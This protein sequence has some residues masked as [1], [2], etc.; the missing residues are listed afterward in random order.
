MLIVGVDLRKNWLLSATL[1]W[2]LKR[3]KV[4]GLV[5]KLKER[6]DAKSSALFWKVRRW[7]RVHP[8]KLFCCLSGPAFMPSLADGSRNSRRS[9]TYW[10]SALH[11][12]VSGRCHVSPIFLS[13]PRWC[14]SFGFLRLTVHDKHLPVGACCTRKVFFLLSIHLE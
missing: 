3:Q 7:R 14:G 12:F 9:Q 10:R 6:H 5:S 4:E 13:T 1:P 8:Q 11:P 2:I